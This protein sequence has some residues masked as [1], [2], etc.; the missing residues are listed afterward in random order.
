[1]MNC[2]MCVRLS[3]GRI[4]SGVSTFDIYCWITRDVFEVMIVIYVYSMSV[5]DHLTKKFRTAM[6]LTK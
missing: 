3:R 6:M 1:M 5:L 4:C 2:G